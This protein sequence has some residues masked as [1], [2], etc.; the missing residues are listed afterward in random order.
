MTAGPD[1]I[2]AFIVRDYAYCPTYQPDFLFPKIS[3][4]GCLSQAIIYLFSVID[5]LIYATQYLVLVK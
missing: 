5:V 4:S 3:F 1:D 2:S